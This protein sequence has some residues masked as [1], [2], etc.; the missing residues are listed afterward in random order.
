[1]ETQVLSG[2]QLS[3]DLSSVLAIGPLSNEC[4]GPHSTEGPETLGTLFV[5][6]ECS[7]YAII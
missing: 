6:Y 7:P 4:L 3:A 2:T 1:V 5:N